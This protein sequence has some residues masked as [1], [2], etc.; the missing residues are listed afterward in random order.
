MPSSFLVSGV[1]AFTSWT[2]ATSITTRVA[3]FLCFVAVLLAGGAVMAR[4]DAATL[5]VT[6]CPGTLTQSTS[7]AITTPA[8]LCEHPAP[9]TGPV[10]N[11]Y[12]RAFN[13]QSFVGGA[14]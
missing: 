13:M 5:I 11:H 3:L 7:Q 12:W 10:E 14:E 8:P 1:D 6:T 9:R 4:V 2:R